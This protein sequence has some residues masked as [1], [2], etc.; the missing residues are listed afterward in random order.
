VN[1]RTEYRLGLPDLDEDARGDVRAS[2]VDLPG[3]G[4]VRF[5]RDGAEVVVTADPNVVS[6][7]EL[8]AAIGEVGVEARPA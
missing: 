3:V 4:E 6:E 2:L 8:L 1:D 7:D 5:G